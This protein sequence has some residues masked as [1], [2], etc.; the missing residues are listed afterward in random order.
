[1]VWAESKSLVSKD[2]VARIM[3][4]GGFFSVLRVAWR[5]SDL[6]RNLQPIHRVHPP[7]LPHL[8]KGSRSLLAMMPNAKGIRDHHIFSRRCPICAIIESY[9]DPKQMLRLLNDPYVSNQIVSRIAA[10]AQLYRMRNDQN[11][12][13]D[14]SRYI[15]LFENLVLMG[16][17]A[18]IPESSKLQCC[19]LQ[20]VLRIYF[21]QLLQHYVRRI[22]QN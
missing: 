9:N 12:A 13:T 14:V 22:L 2:V 8:L 7:E 19:W 16:E 17:D 10:R 20:L 6:L 21:C 5:A 3:D 18:T 11:M 4:C 15:L 1:M